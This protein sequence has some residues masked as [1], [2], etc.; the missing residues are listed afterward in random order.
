[1]NIKRF[2]DLEMWCFARTITKKLYNITGSE[3]FK[4]DYAFQSQIRRCAVSIMANIA[5]GFERNTNKEFIHFLYISKGSAGELR[6]HLYIAMDIGYISSSEFESLETD[7]T[8]ISKS[9]SGLIKYLSRNPVSPEDR[10][11][12]AF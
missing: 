5:E 7:L 10:K 3:Q 9:L 8:R 1:M 6:S 4:R 12:T 2:E 11:K